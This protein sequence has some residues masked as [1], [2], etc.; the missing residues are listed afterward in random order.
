MNNLA[1]KI[2]LVF[3]ALSTLVLATDHE[4]FYGQWGTESQCSRQAIIPNGTKLAAPFD[5]QPDWLGHGD[6]WCRIRW[7]TTTKTSN[8]LVAVAHALCGEDTTRSYNIQ[9]RLAGTE[10]TLIWN[11]WHKN[12]S[13]M[14]CKN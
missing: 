8:G 2:T 13:L 6:T 1:I 12:E 7:G 3:F 4:Q 14:R 9:I 5:I 10:L 11:L